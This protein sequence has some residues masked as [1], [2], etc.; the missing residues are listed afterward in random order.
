MTRS[1]QQAG[2]AVVLCHGCF[3]I[4]HPGHIRHLQQ[5]ARLGD[6]LLVTV[7]GDAAMR[8]GVGRPLIPQELRAENLAALDCVDWVAVCEQ[9]TAI[10]L[11]ADVK[12]DVYVKGREYEHNRDE[13]FA[14]EQ[15]VV[16]SYGGRIVFTSG[17]VVFS[18][19]A[20]IEQMRRTEDTAPAAILRLIEQHGL[21]R[22]EIES[23]LDRAR[24][25]RIVVVGE[26]II[27]TYV[28]CDRPDVAGESPMMTLRPID[29]MSYDGG[30]AIVARHLASL[31][32][33]PT[34]VTALPRTVAAESLRRRLASENV[35]VRAAEIDRPMIEKQRFLVGSSKVMKL[36]LGEPFIMDRARQDE[37]AALVDDAVT[38]CDGV[39]IADF[40]Q[41]LL[42][43]PM[44][45]DI[46][47]RVRPHVRVLAGDVSG[48]RSNLL[49]MSG[50]DLICPSEREIRDALHDYDAGLSAVA[51]SLL[52]RTLSRA[53]IV[54]LGRE[55][56]IAFD[57]R[58]PDAGL[59]GDFS[60]ALNAEHVPSL[61]DHPVDELGCGDALLSA[62]TLALAAGG[63]LPVAALLGSLAA[64]QEAR[65]LGNLVINPTDL[66]RDVRR[67]VATR[68]DNPHAVEP[69]IALHHDQLRPAH[70][71]STRP[72]PADA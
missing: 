60:S 39:I 62:A 70:A 40:G 35:N 50:M 15:K 7:T 47:Q 49:A 19:T 42:T 64:A 16:Q 18:S 14:A 59:R 71:E 65:A 22:D 23:V 20:L 51:W 66:R 26:P 13:R 30:A 56:L 32:A 48:K 21:T 25:K 55:G 9:P 63:S 36:D 58:E 46:C 67:I 44:I 28:M 37:F 33:E 41:G 29:R 38:D 10:D 31:G 6:R 3:D 8:K 43:G 2:E 1:A 52:N 5:A 27:D 57:Q 68:F 53:A 4:V 61:I 17:D 69:V 11:L 12:P 24:G 45:G 54:T 72:A 34:L